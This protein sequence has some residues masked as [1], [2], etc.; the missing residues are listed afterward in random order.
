MVL[1]D[2]KR[3]DTQPMLAVEKLAVGV[4]KIHDF[5][6]LVKKFSQDRV[7]TP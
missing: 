7:A 1:D 6:L 5:F 3:L 2:S 4:C